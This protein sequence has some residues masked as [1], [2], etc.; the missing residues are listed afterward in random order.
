MRKK[1]NDKIAYNDLRTSARPASICLGIQPSKIRHASNRFQT[2]QHRGLRIREQGQQ[3]Q[4]IRAAERVKDAFGRADRRRLIR[5]AQSALRDRVGARATCAQLAPRLCRWRSSASGA[6]TLRQLRLQRRAQTGQHTRVSLSA[7]WFQVDR[8][9]RTM[10]SA[11]A[12]RCESPIAPAT[13]TCKNS[14]PLRKQR[15]NVFNRRAFI[16]KGI[17]QAGLDVPREP[18][19]D[20]PSP[21]LRASVL[22][23]APAHPAH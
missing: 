20:L 5:R 2:G 12:V 17:G 9:G 8:I 22:A 23:Q 6:T 16:G 14:K 3:I 15:G 13:T 18:V 1:L 10:L 21:T 19:R 4:C 7:P 11:N